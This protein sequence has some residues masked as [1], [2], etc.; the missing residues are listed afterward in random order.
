MTYVNYAA[1]ILVILMGMAIL[2]GISPFDRLDENIKWILGSLVVLY[3]TYRIFTYRAAVR[4]YHD[5]YEE[6]DA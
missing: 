1:R 4:R 5:G 6:D 2:G 3:G